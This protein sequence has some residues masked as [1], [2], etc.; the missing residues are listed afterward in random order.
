MLENDTRNA[1]VA[2][3]LHIRG[4][5][6]LHL[7]GTNQLS[8]WFSHFGPTYLHDHFHNSIAS[9]PFFKRSNS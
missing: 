3:T 4:I 9:D 6:K 1:Y 2:H 7:R 8:T 5:V